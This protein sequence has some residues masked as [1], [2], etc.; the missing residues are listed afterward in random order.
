MRLLLPVLLA[1]AVLLSAHAEAAPRRKPGVVRVAKAKAASAKAR[2]PARPS[3][4]PTDY[5]VAFDLPVAAPVPRCGAGRGQRGTT[6]PDAPD[7]Y[8][9]VDSKRTHGSPQLVEMV[10]LAV[11]RVRARV[12]AAAVPWIGRLDQ[13][14]PKRAA[15]LM[16]QDGL[17]A[18]VA[19]W[20][21]GGVQAGFGRRLTAGTLDVRPTWELV[22]AFLATGRTEWILLDQ[23]LID[24]LAVHA[25][26]VE[27][28]TEAQTERVFPAPGATRIWQRRGFLR[29]VP[30]HDNHI[31]VHA[32]C[33]GVTPR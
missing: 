22:R 6:L 8:R 24:A 20:S 16:H 28:W 18:D 23:A 13:L 17:D 21:A 33:E 15:F 27:G 10:R 5:P 25:R 29:H 32:V 30:G 1:V 31:H 7:L 9:K 3:A 2:T 26:R 12:P 11:A 19:L 14:S 4:F